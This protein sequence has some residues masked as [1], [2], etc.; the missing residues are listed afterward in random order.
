[1]GLFFFATSLMKKSSNHNNRSVVQKEDHMLKII[2][3]AIVVLVAAL[4]VF[5]ATKPD[6]FRVERT[7]TIKATPEKIFPFLND[8]H[9]GEA[10]SPYEKKD[11]AMKRTYSGV[12]SGKGSVYV[13]EGNKKVGTGRLEIIESVPPSKVVI[14]LDMRKP[15]EGHNIIEYTLE[16]RGDNT[17][18]T[19]AI[20]GPNSYLAKVMCIFV[21]MDKMIGKDFETGLANLKAVAEK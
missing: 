21:S 15:F 7:A 11:P 16:P 8:F 20:H 1:V 6:T 10:W 12:T 5:A 17:N 9:K 14:S 13:F 3:I 4:L 19:W 2:G 18:F